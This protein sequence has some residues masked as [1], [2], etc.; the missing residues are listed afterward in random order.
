MSIPR[1]RILSSLASLP[2]A[3]SAPRNGPA[4][5]RPQSLKRPGGGVDWPAVRA[6]FTLDPEWI[7]LASFYLVSHPRRVQAA[8]EDF[9]RKL[10]RDPLWLDQAAFDPST[11]LP[12][13][14]VRAA[15][16]RYT[17]AR[18]Q[19]LAFTP[20][21]TTALALVYHG[22]RLRAGQEVL[23]T[24]HDHYSH[25][26]SIRLAAE[27]ADATVRRIRLYDRGADASASVC[28]D[29]LERGI[30]P[31]TRAVGLTWVHSSTGVKLPVAALA[32]V[33]S[34]A[35]RGRAAE[36]RILLIVD[37]VHG[38]GNQ[39]VDVASL[40]AD[41]FAAGCHKWLFGPRGTGFLWGRPEAWSELRPTIP[42]FDPSAPETWEAWMK[43]QPPGPTRAAWVSPGGFVAFEH[44][45]ALGESIAFH[46]EIGRPAL[47][48]RIAELNSRCR[49]GLAGM[50]HVTLHTPRSSELAG[51]VAC[52]EV[53]GLSAEEVTNRLAAKRIR[54]NTSPYATSYARIAVGI[55]NTP[56]EV[57]RALA[58]VRSL[59]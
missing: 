44:L 14:K 36:D 27:R 38:F 43:G 19:D 23:T 47:A 55:M 37:G 48:A 11:G 41:F 56:E 3:W 8:I 58:A 24:E 25:H 22:L 10:D 46:E 28:V 13:E 35:N 4:A 21:T 26:E 39:D 7:H 59:A 50:K 45:L 6:Q 32:E 29:R 20:N 30:G 34:R 53:R 18:P 16:A 12:L 54:T 9:R 49:E 2:L 52:F 5:E 51:P 42:T 17:G 31:K 57:D 15:L 1:R 40:G 33:V